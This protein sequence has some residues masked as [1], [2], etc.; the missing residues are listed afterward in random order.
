MSNPPSGESV[1]LARLMPC[2][3]RLQYDSRGL[4]Q[5]LV[6]LDDEEWLVLIRWAPQQAPW[7]VSALRRVPRS[8]SYAP[9]TVELEREVGA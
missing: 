7:L 5:W 4:I 1:V 6:T 8:V 2:V 3:Q 9:K